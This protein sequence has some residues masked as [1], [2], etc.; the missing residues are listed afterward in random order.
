ML[1]ELDEIVLLETTFERI[2]DNNHPFAGSIYSYIPKQILEVLNNHRQKLRI[3]PETSGNPFEIIKTEMIRSSIPLLTDDLYFLRL[4]TTG[5]DSLVS[6]NSYNIVEYLFYKSLLSDEEKFN[7]ISKICSLGIRHPN[8]SIRLLANTLSYF[9]GVG[10]EIDYANTAFKIIF[11]KVFSS[12][13]NGNDVFQVLLDTLLC[14]SS[15]PVFPLNSDSLLSLFRGF[16][17][18]HQME[19]LD[20]LAIFWFIYQC[21]KT[22]VVMK[23]E[24]VQVSLLHSK[25]WS[26]YVDMMYKIKGSGISLNEIM[27]RVV[28]QLFVLDNNVRQLAVK[29]IKSCFIP[30]TQ[31]SE[32]FTKLLDEISIKCRL[33]NMQR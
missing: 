14:A 12:T 16:L 33:T 18:R 17:I 22:P 31:E 30:L 20:S 24:H 5:N 7:K 28:M 8:M 4:T 29:N 11:D 21:T 10:N 23:S 6:L 15:N 9:T 2:K 19:S 26:V 32:L 13:R 25:Y 1:T 3:L 27:L